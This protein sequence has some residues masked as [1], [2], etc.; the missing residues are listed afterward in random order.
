ML[1]LKTIFKSFPSAF[2]PVLRGI[3]LQ[4]AAGDFCVIVGSNGSG[5]ST[6]LKTISGEY[7]CDAGQIILDGQEITQRAL[8]ERATMISGVVQD[9][10]KGIIPEMT[11]LENLA[12]SQLRQE[13]ASLR[14]YRTR[15]EA[16]TQKVIEL[17]LGLERYLD[18]L[19]G[20]LSGGQRQ[21]MALVMATLARPKLLLL[22]EHC[23]ALDPKSSLMLMKY[24][25][26]LVAQQQLTTLMITHNLHDALIYGNRL[27]MLHQGEIVL[28]I[29]GE[30]KK[31]LTVEKL[32][33]MF[34]HYEDAELAS[35]QD[36]R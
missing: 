14:F 10:T 5:K 36:E 18:T 12:L 33:A 32:L 22:D 1:I 19:M 8:Y 28:D 29:S 27:I 11:L 23:S 9:I 30:K 7:S 20:S 15:Q 24:T 13:K 16:L 17:G 6:L 4:L 34:H 26:T 35:D 3:S 2:K 31:E 21:M 25:A